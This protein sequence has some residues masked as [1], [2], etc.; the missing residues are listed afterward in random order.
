MLLTHEEIAQMIATTRGTV[1]KKIISVKGASVFILKKG[2]L[3]SM[4]T[5]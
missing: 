5:I 1:Q 2:Q 3:E 4:V